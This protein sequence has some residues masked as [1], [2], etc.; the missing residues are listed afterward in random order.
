[1]LPRVFRLVA[2]ELQRRGWDPIVLLLSHPEEPATT[3]DSAPGGIEGSAPH[4]RRWL[5]TP[6]EE[7]EKLTAE[8]DARAARGCTSPWHRRRRQYLRAHLKANGHD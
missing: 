3:E 5:F 8:I 7:I 2:A 6:A 4:R 1:L